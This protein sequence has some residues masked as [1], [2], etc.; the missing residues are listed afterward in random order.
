MSFVRP[1]PGNI[2][3]VAYGYSPIQTTGALDLIFNGGDYVPPPASDVSFLFNRDFIR[4]DISAIDF[5]VSAVEVVRRGIFSALTA[6]WIAPQNLTVPVT[7]VMSASRTA[8]A[9]ID[10]AWSP[11]LSIENGIAVRWEKI[12]KADASDDF[13]WPAL[14]LS[15][16]PRHELMWGSQCAR[17]VVSENR[18]FGL[19]QREDS[20]VDN[21]WFGA[22][23]DDRVSAAIWPDYWQRTWRIVPHRYPDLGAIDFAVAGGGVDVWMSGGTD[24]VPDARPVDIRFDGADYIPPP[25]DFPQLAFLR[26]HYRSADIQLSRAIE[27]VLNRHQ[28][29]LLSPAARDSVNQIAW[30]LSSS[31]DGTRQLPWAKYSRPL[32]PGWGIVVPG[33]PPTPGAGASITIPIRRY[34]IMANEVFLLRIE[35]N[36]MIPATDLSISFDRDSWCHQLS[37]T[38]PYSYLDAVMPSPAPVK[39]AAF[40]NGTEFRILVERVGTTRAFGKKSVVISGRSVACEIDT[41]YVA[42]PYRTNAVAM[43]A[44]QLIG[45]ALEYSTYSQDWRIDDWLVPAGAL[46]MAGS[47]ISVAGHVAEAAGAVLAADWSQN[48]LRMMPRYPVKPWDWASATPDYIIPAA[49]AETE[50]IEWTETPAFNAVFISGVDQGIVA[51]VKRA[52]TA[53][54]Q[55]APMITHPL[56]SHP[57][58]ASQKG[59]SVLSAGGRKAT[60][61][62]T[63]PVLDEVGIVEHCRLIEFSDGG[64]TRRGVTC[65]NNIAAGW[66]TLRQTITVE[67]LA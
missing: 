54:D 26:P 10:P 32:N 14:L 11:S 57:V 6:R 24:I 12:A 56:I 28:Q 17:D 35:G 22:M 62:I 66:P 59:I 67:T 47:P 5:S 31:A 42:A 40:V 18:W 34:Y 48:V 60:M 64:K 55:V 50:S 51:R 63:M 15:L 29:I 1:A 2:S 20:G 7:A 25:T 13:S 38:V 19:L 37:A 46:S 36:M 39:V 23:P 53:G 3:L 9:A 41:P 33:G 4:P 21:K 49:V 8:T 44:Q 45:A 16:R 61:Q 43:T 65:G 58:A 30:N 52:G 27:L